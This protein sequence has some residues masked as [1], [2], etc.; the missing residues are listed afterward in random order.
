M[1][2]KAL[3]IVGLWLAVS[4]LGTGPVHSQ[5]DG[6]GGASD[7]RHCGKEAAEISQRLKKADGFYSTFK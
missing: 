4:L 2:R 1:G 6:Q 7:C 5:P 3:F